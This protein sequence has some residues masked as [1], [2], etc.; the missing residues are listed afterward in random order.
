MLIRKN[1]K[2]LKAIVQIFNQHKNS[3]IINNFFKLF[4]VKAG[5]KIDQKIETLGAEKTSLESLLTTSKIPTEMAQTGKR[6]KAIE[7]DLAALEERWL[8]LTE[9]IEVAAV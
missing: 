8:Q 5:E 9:Q 3:K 1:T 2:E 7:A 4:I 6:L